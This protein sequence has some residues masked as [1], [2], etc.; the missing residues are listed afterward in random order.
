MD[1]MPTADLQLQCPH[2]GSTTEDPWEYFEEGKL[3][4]L[5]C[6]GCGRNFHVYVASCEVVGCFRETVFTWKDEPSAA[7]IAALSCPACS[8]P[9][10]RQD[11]DEDELL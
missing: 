7:T 8:T 3:D 9:Y 2:C 5:R 11:S 10:R 6:E 4:W 1:P